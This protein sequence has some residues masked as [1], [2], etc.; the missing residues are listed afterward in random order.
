MTPEE[1]FMKRCIEL[2]LNGYGHVAPNP[3]VGCVIV[4]DDKI[5][6]EGYHQQFGKAHAEVN[7]IESVKD[8]TLL[9][10][11]TLYVSLEP[12]SHHGKTPPC[13]DMII[14][15]KIPHVM[16]GCADAFSEVNGRGIAALKNGG[17]KVM[18]NILELECRNLN[19]R[20]FT[21]HEKKR[22]YI[23]LKWAQSKDGF[24]GKRNVAEPVT[25][26]NEL[27]KTLSHKWRSEEA[28]IIIGTKTAIADN[29]QLN[30]RLWSGKN[31]LRIVIDK[32]L[33][34]PFTHHLYSHTHPTVIFNAVK[35]EIIENTEFVRIDF[36]DNSLSTI[37]HEIY[38]RKINSI[39]I[40]GGTNLLSQFIEQNL[41]DE[42]RVFTGTTYLKE[43][44][45]S[46][47]FNFPAY[48]TEN[49]MGDQLQFFYRSAV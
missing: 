47:A 23:I 7:A 33:K 49:I 14:K 20:F 1:L 3:L 36:S 37:L 9:S 32:D 6:G 44:V 27:S 16:I 15:H 21:Y 10:N 46:P 12:C 13:V 24:I 18:L 11:S 25:I 8:K 34:I 30:T 4:Y 22:P 31:P 41:W 40:E 5:I 39:L 38:K 43:G 45:P 19:K 17:I 2:A 29:P 48:S 42:A 35:N 26:S 28:A